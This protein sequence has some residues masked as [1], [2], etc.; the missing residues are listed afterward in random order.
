MLVNRNYKYKILLYFL[1]KSIL[2]ILIL[3]KIIIKKFINLIDIIKTLKFYIDK[4][5]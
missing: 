4:L 1:L 5:T 3:L 2:L